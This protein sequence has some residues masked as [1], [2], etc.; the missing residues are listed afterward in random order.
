M[1]D[2]PG[3]L[4]TFANFLVIALG[5]GLIV[6]IHEL[7]HFLAAKWAG[8]RVLAFSIG[9]GQVACS[10]RKGMGFRLGSSEPEYLKRAYGLSVEETQALHK[11]VS[12]TE[13]RLS[14][15]PL[16]GYV[17]MLGQEDLNPDAVSDEPDSYQNCSVFKRMVVIS[18]GVIMNVI[19]AAILF[20]IVFNAGLKVFPA[21]LGEIAP[22]GPAAIATPVNRDD[23]GVGLQRG[24]RVTEI[25]GKK[26]Y[27]FEH[28]LPE[29]AMARKGKPVSIIVER[30][31][32]DG[33]I[34]FET[35]PVKDPMTGLLGI[36]VNA[37]LSTQARPAVSQ[38]DERQVQMFAQSAGI[39]GLRAGDTITRVGDQP[40]ISPL[41]LIDAAEASAGFAF[42]ITL[43]REDGATQESEIQP[44]H[45]IQTGAIAVDDGLGG[46][47]H[48]LG[49][50]GVMMVNPYASPEDTKQGL[51][52]GDIFARVGDVEYPNIDEG[53]TVV[54]RNAG[55]PLTLEVLRGD[56]QSGYERVSL[57]V[58]VSREGRIGFFPAM[59][60]GHAP[61][62]HKPIKI[63]EFDPVRYATDKDYDPVPVTTPAHEIIDYSGSRILQIAGTDVA[64]LR[65]VV[66]ILVER[67]NDAFEAGEQTFSVPV[68][69]ELP[70]PMQP[71][72]SIPTAS[73]S[74]ELSRADIEDL[75]ELGWA[76]PSN[77]A[78]AQLFQP[79]QVLDR[80]P[81]PIAAIQ[82][83]VAESRRVMMQT[84][85][86]FLRLFE[87]SV[88]VRH[89]K[90]PVGIAHLGTQIASQGFIWVLFFMAL[91][92]I[93]LA[94]I[95]FL[96]IPIVDGG[97]F[98][99]LCY[100]WIRGRPVPIVVQNVATLAGLVFIGVMF[101][102]VTFNDIKNI[103]G[104]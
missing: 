96:P 54:Q 27:S 86:T 4:G 100:E 84:Y 36:Q 7:G 72:G 29:I 79:Y 5:F 34:E 94:V 60:T 39:M 6:F 35:T 15:L 22:D 46:I 90:G 19:S 12:P 66:G 99:M 9:F 18:A 97:Q 11:E 23:V 83:G 37:P 71:D 77:S 14:W 45:A 59:S 26:M 51:M 44:V 61:I 31:G 64:D 65:D 20:V 68:V 52:P 67:T 103:F 87:G 63:A 50:H 62:V 85:L 102:Y 24:D 75:R 95:N 40:A 78:M 41:D 38:D 32:V 47:E 55:K 49:L 21:Q 8:I 89:L 70:L 30:A 1:F 56:P 33:P 16:G 101:L 73:K 10:Y 81:S 92:S 42:T 25:N 3:P 104:A 91:I 76:L 28:I 82:R 69:I 98:L 80:S 93:N 2:L 43:T 53:I 58:E 48:V 13:Y 17:K 88:E 57:D 74:W